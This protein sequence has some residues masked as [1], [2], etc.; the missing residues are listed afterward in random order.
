MEGIHAYFRQLDETIGRML[1]KAGPDAAVFF[2]SDH[3]FGPLRRKA[4]INDY[5]EKRGLLKIKHGRLRAYR[6]VG[7]MRRL[8]GM[9]LRGVKRRLF[10]A[11]KRSVRE[12][13]SMATAMFYKIFYDSIDWS[14]TKAYMASN[15]E[16]GIYV[17]LKGREPFGIVE[18]ADYETVCAEVED[19]LRAF[20]DENGKR[21]LTSLYRRDELYSG[22][23]SDRAP[24]VIFFLE[25]GECLAEIQLA[26]KRILRETTWKTG[27]GM[28]RLEGFF[29]AHGP[30]IRP[31]P[32]LTTHI[33]NVMP[34][35]LYAMGLPIP[36][37]LD[38]KLIDEIF[39]EEYAAAHEPAY[40]GSALAGAAEAGEALSDEEEAELQDRLRRLGY[41]D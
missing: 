3:G 30:G 16:Q 37:D 24:D 32:D 12:Q 35:I 4:A 17:N 20:E 5:L 40:A 14:R 41:M 9:M 6:A 10:A 19:A 27:T 25:E 26:S 13:T 15:T 36:D 39:T 31:V 1:A 18:P 38:G 34:T 8:A 22:P 23:F 33:M 28:H 29:L 7:A 11:R 2:V 21:L